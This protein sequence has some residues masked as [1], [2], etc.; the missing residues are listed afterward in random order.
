M[1]R[2]LCSKLGLADNEWPKVLV[3]TVWLYNRTPHAALNHKCPYELMP[4]R[5]A[6]TPGLTD[7]KHLLHA[8]APSNT[9]PINDPSINDM[10]HQLQE[11]FIDLERGIVDHQD[12]LR[13]TRQ[14][15]WNKKHNLKDDPN[16]VVGSY[17]MLAREGAGPYETT[18]MQPPWYGPHRIVEKLHDNK[19]RVQLFGSDL[20]EIAVIDRVRFL[21]YSDIEDILQLQHYADASRP[22]DQMFKA[23]IGHTKIGRNKWYLEIKWNDN[24]TTFEHLTKFYRDLP[25]FVTQYLH[26]LATD[27]TTQSA[28]SAMQQIT[29]LYDKRLANKQKQSTSNNK[30]NHKTFNRKTNDE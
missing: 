7:I 12:H 4:L 17:V 18:K 2:I 30:I 10:L 3:P 27:P 19:I 23:I 6:I 20:E 22:G 13:I 5:H 24:T 8:A 25:H 14:Q 9:T 28:S 1:V 16:L 29:T 21:D 26:Q 11:D 15:L